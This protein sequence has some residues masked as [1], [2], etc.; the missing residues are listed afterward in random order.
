MTDEDLTR[1]KHD[2]DAVCQKYNFQSDAMAG[3]LADFLT[4]G[5]Q[6]QAQEMSDTF[7]MT[8]KD[9]NTFLM[10]IS[11]GTRFKSEVID[12]NARAAREGRL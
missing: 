2:F 12:R 9:A 10:W 8:M 7:G 3:K 11:I 6:V 1:L 5:R 4:G